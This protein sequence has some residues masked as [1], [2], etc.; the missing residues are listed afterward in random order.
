MM[1]LAET[2]KAIA[3]PSYNER[4]SDNW[5][6]Y[7]KRLKTVQNSEQIIIFFSLRYKIVHVK[8]ITRYRQ[9]RRRC[10]K[11]LLATT[12]YNLLQLASC[13]QVLIRSKSLQCT[14]ARATSPLCEHSVELLG[15][16]LLKRC[17][18]ETF[19][20]AKFRAHLGYPTSHQLD[21]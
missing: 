3:A 4:Y 11:L 20:T 17:F 5:Q 9:Y 16:K 8:E 1:I 6:E 15:G 14:I 2:S 10:Y 12:N 13:Y 7:H 19:E 21:P 18:P